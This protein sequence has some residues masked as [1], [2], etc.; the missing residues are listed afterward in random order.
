MK[1]VN[2]LLRYRGFS[3]EHNFNGWWIGFGPVQGEYQYLK[4]DSFDGLKGFITD[5]LTQAK[6]KRIPYVNR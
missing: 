4:S 5:T 3:I 2:K 6:A 1:T